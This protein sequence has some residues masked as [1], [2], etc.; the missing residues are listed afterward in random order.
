MGSGIPS[1][2]SLTLFTGVAE[3]DKKEEERRVRCVYVSST[4][5]KRAT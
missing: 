5:R 2:T 3:F 4:L 1:P